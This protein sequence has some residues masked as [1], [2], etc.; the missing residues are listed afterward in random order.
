MRG[1]QISKYFFST[2]PSFIINKINKPCT[3]CVHYIPYKCESMFDIFQTGTG[4]CALFGQE[5]V[6]TGKMEYYDVE[7]CRYTNTKCGREGKYYIKK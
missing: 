7:N 5:E 4:K 1:I 3:T 6:V 2:S